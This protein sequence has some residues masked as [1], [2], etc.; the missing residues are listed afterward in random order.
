MTNDILIVDDEQD[1][2]ELI[3]DILED[4]HYPT[5][6]A[7]DSISALKAVEMRMPSCVILDIWLQGSPLDGLGILEV[8]KDSNLGTYIK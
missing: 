7:H 6:Q 2:R 5:M 8:L 4:E 3:A 1:I